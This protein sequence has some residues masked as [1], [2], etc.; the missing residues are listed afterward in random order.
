MAASNN[1]LLQIEPFVVKLQTTVSSVEKSIDLLYSDFPILEDSES[2]FVDFYIHIAKPKSPG[3]Y[4]K[5]QVQCYIDGKSP[6]KPLPFSQA[7][8]FFEWGLNWAVAQY[9]YNQLIIH[10]AVLEKGGYTLIL[11]GKPGAGK[12]TLCAALSNRG[13]RLLSDEMCIVDLKSNELIPFVR[14]V[15]LKNKAIS[16]IKEYSPECVMGSSYVDTAKGTVAHMKPSEESVVKAKLRAVARWV[17]FPRY[18]E[19]SET[20]LHTIPKGETVIELAKNSFNYNILGA[21]GFSSLCELVGKSDCYSFEYSNLD[22]AIDLFN[23]LS[24]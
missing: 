6:F 20:T 16:L 11:C 17:V 1:I 3:G 12:S 9:V 5:S 7:Y 8:P 10:A 4:L 14:P 21:A 23:N 19:N 24:K 18:R 13:W 22:E 2:V 15:S